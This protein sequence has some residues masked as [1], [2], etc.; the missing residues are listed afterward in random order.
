MFRQW[1]K[2]GFATWKSSFLLQL[3]KPSI[4]ITTSESDPISEYLCHHTCYSDHW[5]FMA[6]PVD[7]FFKKP[8]V[9]TFQIC[10]IKYWHFQDNVAP[11]AASSFPSHYHTRLLTLPKPVVDAFSFNN[12][13]HDL[14]PRG[15][16][17]WKLKTSKYQISQSL[18]QANIEKKICRRLSHTTIIRS[19]TGPLTPEINDLSIKCQVTFIQTWRPLLSSGVFFAYKSFNM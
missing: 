8:G 14:W 3:Q 11:G 16:R 15:T 4:F 7:L 17:I 6:F 10:P 19:P 5:R 9:K 18:Q 1:Y 12:L 13:R 2:K